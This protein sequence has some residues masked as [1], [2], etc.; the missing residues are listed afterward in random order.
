MSARVTAKAVSQVSNQI[1][2]FIVE[3][4]P[5]YEK[6][7]KNYYEFLETLCVY[8]TEVGEYTT[9]FTSGE[10]VTGQ[11]SGG[12]AK[13]RGF[14]TY[15]NSSGKVFLDLTN[16]LDLLKDEVIIGGTSNSRGTI[17]SISRKPLNGTKTFHELINPDLTTD[18]IL[19]WFKKNFKS[20][21]NCIFCFNFGCCT[22][23]LTSY[24]FPICKCSWI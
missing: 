1:P 9:A 23:S 22:R 18:G 15:A 3:E 5:L 20:C 12:T 21:T 2:Q 13:V 7:L 19:D 6:F 14:G 24:S 17:T 10:T 8:Y 16:D 4:H 11:T